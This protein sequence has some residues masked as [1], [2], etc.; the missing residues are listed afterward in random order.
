MLR[1]RTQILIEGMSKY[2]MSHHRVAIVR[3]RSGPD[4]VRIVGAMIIAVTGGRFGFVSTRSRIHAT[5]DAPD[6]L[7]GRPTRH[8]QINR[9][10]DAVILHALKTPDG[11]AKHYAVASV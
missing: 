10:I 3:A 4:H 8:I 11:L 2:A 1:G 9:D 7:V 6:C 5:V